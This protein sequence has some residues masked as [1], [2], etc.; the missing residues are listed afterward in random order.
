MFYCGLQKW[1]SETGW[2]REHPPSLYLAGY[3]EVVLAGMAGDFDK[4]VLDAILHASASVTVL[5]AR[6][7]RLF[8]ETMVDGLVNMVGSVTRTVGYSLRVVQTGRLR[9]Y[10]MWIAVGVVVL[11][12]VLFTSLPK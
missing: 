11:F 8:D 3:F 7:D 2:N 9:Q 1:D 4:K 10:V 12:G 6:W 5:V